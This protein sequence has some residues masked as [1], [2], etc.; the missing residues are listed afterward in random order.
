MR[1]KLRI[2]GA[3]LAMLL[4]V[5]LL[6]GCGLFEEDKPTQETST[7]VDKTV[8]TTQ[9][10]N[11]NPLVKIWPEFAKQHEAKIVCFEMGWTGP[12][13]DKDF[14]TPEIAKRTGF[15]LNYEP[16]TLAT[17][18]DLNQKLN[19]MVASQDVPDIFFGQSD[20]YS[21]S[22][23]TKLGE[24]GL[25]WD[26]APQIK[27]Y[28]TIYNLVKPELTLFKT[29]D[30]SY[31]IPTQTG[32]GNDA[33]HSAASGLFVRDDLL[34]K[35]NMPYPTTPEEIYT[36]LKRCKEELKT[37]DGKA[38]IPY[39][40]DEN[41][42]GVDN[43][44]VAFLPIRS[45]DNNFTF[46]RHDNYKVANYGYTDSPELMRGAKFIN[47]LYQE[48]LIDRESLTQKRAQF[49]EKISSG[50]I[51][52]MSCAWWD[53][54][55]FS[56]NAK[57]VVPDLMYV[58]NPQL[59]DKTNGVPKYPDDK[60]T[61]GIY[62][63]STLI[64]SKKVSEEALKHF[65]ATLDYLATK[66]GQVLVQAGIE[67]KSFTYDEN[68]K[69]KFT[70]EFKQQTGNLDWNK[71]SSFGV[72]YWQQL[73][74]N[75]PA[76]DS[77]RAEYPE[78]VREDNKKGWENQQL[79][80]DHYDPNMTPPKDYYFVAGPVEIQKFPAI[81]D[82]RSEMLAKVLVAK[83]EAEVEKVIHEWAKTCKDMGIDDIIKE[84]QQYMDTFDISA[85]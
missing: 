62:S 3:I 29:K 28:E 10:E 34:K 73:V 4:V 30:K 70:E 43:L 55:T 71:G 59:F 65:L 51:A 1:K 33:L 57:A 54:N 6:A 12:E 61:S 32:K 19:L 23:Y 42:G 37:A 69:Y 52:A 50:R 79:N 21:R 76:Y 26:I 68:G 13:K 36:Y 47:K 80:R 74:M 31:F 20:A 9:A 16:M 64:V 2:P 56:D 85:Q 11:A 82:A 40:L 8:E 35:L 18:D 67:G 77:L 41:L 27:N 84:R 7:S 38:M 39:T 53:M 75:L 66:D 15:Q 22:I 48:G 25:I 46:D 58:A 24:S 60:W 45:G 49:Q 17:G 63:W 83:S 81:Q 14:V 72:Y 5:S 78:L 44:M